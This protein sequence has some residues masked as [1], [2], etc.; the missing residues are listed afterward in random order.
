MS[1]LDQKCN[2][3]RPVKYA[4][5]KDGGGHVMSCN[6]HIV[7]PTYEELV[8]TNQELTRELYKKCALLDKIKSVMADLGV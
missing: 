3:G 7:C 1:S 4:H 8:K 6:K 2:C 5:I